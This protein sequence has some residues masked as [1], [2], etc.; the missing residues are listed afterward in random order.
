M[1]N[2]ICLVIVSKQKAEQR[3]LVTA[4]IT[5]R[6]EETMWSAY[7]DRIFAWADKT[8][9]NLMVKA[10]AGCGKTTTIVELYKRLIAKYPLATVLFMAFNKKIAEELGNRGVPASTMNAFGHKV[11]MKSGKLRLNQYKIR[12]MCKEYHIDY[13]HHGLVNRCVDLLKAYLYPMHAVTTDDVE[14]IIEEFELSDTRVAKSML[15]TIINIFVQSLNNWSEIDF[16]DQISYPVYHHLPIPKYDFV[17][18]D[19]AQDLSPNK[20]EMVSRAVGN[21]FVCV[22]DPFQAIYGFAGADSTSMDKI[23]EQFQPVI[24]SLPV[25]YRCGRRIVEEAH[26]QEVAPEDFQAGPDNHD[27]VVG[28]KSYED[29]EREVVANDFVLCRLTAPLVS[30]CFK[31]IKKGIRAQILGRDVGSKLINLG[32]QIQSNTGKIELDIESHGIGVTTQSMEMR[33]FCAQWQTY[34]RSEVNKLRDAGKDDKADNLEDQLECLFVFAEGA[35]SIDEMNTKIS[36]LFDDVINPG[37]IIFSTIHKAKG[38]EADNVWALPYKSKKPSN[39]KQKQEEKNLKYVQ[40]TRAK[41]AF[42]YVCK[43]A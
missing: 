5:M 6:R 42:Y 29:F 4:A 37:S 18:I 38:L 39:E 2:R 33:I 31:L 25:T 34:K 8:E 9:T 17:I 35:S 20:L 13:K 7:Q 3:S 1:T 32:K 16:T 36:R 26:K 23:A 24:M 27:G 19:E 28:N 21:R 30:G 41:N 12:D 14:K 10:G 43:G 40:I 22:G 11:C 15:E